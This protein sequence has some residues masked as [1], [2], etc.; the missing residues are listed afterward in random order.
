MLMSKQLRRAGHLSRM[1]E[2]RMPKAVFYGELCQGKRDRGAPRKR[3][4]DQL[5]HQLSSAGIPVREWESIATDRKTW[6]AACK[7][8][9][10]SFEAARRERKQRRGED[11]G[12]LWPT[13]LHMHRASIAHPAPGDPTTLPTFASA[14]LRVTVVGLDRMD[15]TLCLQEVQNIRQ[16]LKVVRATTLDNVKVQVEL[17][18]LH[19]EIVDIKNARLS[20]LQYV[21]ASRRATFADVVSENHPQS[22]VHSPTSRPPP[23]P[24]QEHIQGHG[25]T[26]KPKSLATVSRSPRRRPRSGASTS[27]NTDG[28][29]VV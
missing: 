21:Q 14:S 27:S 3:Y 6:K 24:T 5:K 9:A 19:R 22:T 12:K 28:F 15:L 13:S 10:E 18:A 7:R 20:V 26:T 16:E 2:S 17:A 11:E 1:E 8:G 4:K 29:T 25:G 23:G